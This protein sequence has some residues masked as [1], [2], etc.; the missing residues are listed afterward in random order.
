MIVA[1]IQARME[2]TRL[3]GKVLKQI[4]TKPMLWHLWN[5]LINS[6]SIDQVVVATSELPSNDPIFDFCNSHNIKCFRGS[7]D[8]VV[9]R[10][11][12]A[13]IAFKAD[14]IVAVTGDCPLVDPEIADRVINEFLRHRPHLCAT[15]PSYT[16]PDGFGSEVLSMQTLK[17]IHQEAKGAMER[18]HLTVFLR[19]NRPRFQIRFLENPAYCPFSDLHLS[20]DDEHDFEL[21]RK[22]FKALLPEKPLFTLE[23]VV[24]KLRSNPGWLKDHPQT[25]INEGYFKSFF[26]DLNYRKPN[27]MNLDLTN[28]RTLIKRAAKVIPSCTQTFSKGYTQYVQGV[29]P[30]F[31]EKGSGGIV[32]DVDGNDFIDYPLALGAITLGHCYPKVDERVMEQMRKGPSHSLPHRLEVE[33]AE[34]LC[35]II[36]CA[37]MVR[38]GKNGSDATSGAVRVARAVTGREMIAYCGYH[39]WQD[40]YIGTTLRNRGVPDSTKELTKSFEYNNISSLEKIFDAHPQRIAAVIMEPVGSILPG[41]GYLDKVKRITNKNGAVLIFDEVATGGRIAMGGAQEYF[42]VTPD[43]ACFGKGLGNG[44]PISAVV[45]KKE[46]MEEFDRSF[47]SFTFGGEAVSLAAVLATI[48]VFENNNVF[49]HMWVLGRKLKDGY[50]Y[51]SKKYDLDR[52]TWCQGLPPKAAIV[53]KDKEGHD[54]LLFKSIFMQECIKR[55]VLFN[56][57][58][59][60]CLMHTNEQVEYTI[61]VYDEAFKVLKLAYEEEN[62]HAFLEGTML[63]PV[64]RKFD[65]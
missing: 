34:K 52:Y 62:A 38:F 53:Y 8:D 35:E 42:G 51:L 6:K 54:S 13:A 18:E 4:D 36:P 9:D 17:L 19:K 32:W 33:L 56:G 7:E 45:G 15:S 29:S 37:E 20:V 44:Y 50:N 23:D 40:W 24:E 1:C 16:Y 25:P 49:S 5:R 31:V 61:S 10:V 55:K 28:S 60:F 57:L 41:D 22:I 3:P 64:F 11:Y 59:K 2:S 58:H 30:I 43:L 47:F 14:T 26:N 46:I 12:N 39:G 65:Y 63:E 21:V 48:D 27:A